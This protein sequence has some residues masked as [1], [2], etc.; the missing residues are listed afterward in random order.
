MA[1]QVKYIA[2]QRFKYDGKWLKAGDEWK[3]VGA[4]YDES[5]IRNRLVSTVRIE[6]KASKPLTAAAKE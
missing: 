2:R 6:T 3:P 1:E 5:I 4:R